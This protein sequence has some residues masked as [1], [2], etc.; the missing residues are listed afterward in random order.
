MIVNRA[1]LAPAV[2]LSALAALAP[3]AEAIE[4]G[5]VL[6]I[7]TLPRAGG[8]GSAPLVDRA[9][10]VTVVVFFKA[11]H[12]RSEEALRALAGCQPRL[13][14]K[15][16]G[17]VGV[18]PPDSAAGAAAAVAAAGVKLPVLVDAEEAV[19]AAA[20]I[21][22]HP[23]V[24]V[25]DRARRV[26]AAEPYHP[27]GFCDAVVA[28]VRQA[29]G[30]IGEAEVARAL[31]PPPS[32]LPGDSPG[33]VAHRHVSFGR[34]LLAARSLG[35]AHEEARKAI[36]LAPSA[37]A[38]RLEGE[39]FAA[40]GR[41]PDAVKAFDAALAIDPGDSAAAAARQACGR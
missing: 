39:V 22:M 34:K 23:F 13:A 3:R 27:V 9:S 26:A 20:R 12:E 7:V 35:A 17:F 28:R 19:Y 2:A 8:G 37:D 6:P 18:V 16:V 21:R 32:Q 15:P 29:L 31:A 30:E 4:P 24:A 38:W 5:Q 41:C 33:A 11:P 40:E 10:A 14:G 25:A 1:F 36:A